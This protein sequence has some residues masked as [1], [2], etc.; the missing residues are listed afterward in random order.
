MVVVFY[1]FLVIEWVSGKF[2]WKLSCV[3]LD[4]VVGFFELR[5]FESLVMG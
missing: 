3:V 1:F 2:G 4:K 5:I